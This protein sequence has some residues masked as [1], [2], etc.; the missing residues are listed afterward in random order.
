MVHDH[1]AGDATLIAALRAA[2]T[3]AIR[4]LMTRAASQLGRSEA[5]LYRENRGRIP[6]WAWQT[7]HHV[8][9][10]IST[11]IADGA[12]RSARTGAVTLATNG[13]NVTIL[14]DVTN[15]RSVRAGGVTRLSLQWGRISFGTRKGRITSV[16]GPGT[17]TVRIRT[18]YA[19]GANPEG[20]SAYGRGTTSA[21]VAGGRV[22]PASTT[23]RFHE[24]N[25]GLDYMEFFGSNRPPQFTGA[26]GMTTEEFR[27]AMREWRTATRQYSDDVNA[28][29]RRNT[30]C[31]GT[32]IDDHH[33]SEARPG[34]SIVLQ[35][36]P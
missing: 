20:P 4:V 30:D 32:T 14:P 19:R 13:F 27:T 23:L 26:A 22:T 21:D 12:V 6:M 17:P 18:R 34:Q 10:G 15:D 2:Y 33:T 31:V 5:D 8:E 3:A 7:A 16:T 1:L 25:H 9:S 11:P 28:F 24:G 35:C 36:G 29:S